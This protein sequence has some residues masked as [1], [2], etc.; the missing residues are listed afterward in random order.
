MYPHADPSKSVAA[1]WIQIQDIH[2][3]M[4]Y[5]R[6]FVSSFLRPWGAANVLWTVEYRLVRLQASSYRGA[7]KIH[8]NVQGH[9][10][11]PWRQK[12]WASNEIFI[13]KPSCLS[14]NNQIKIA[15]CWIP[16][17]WTFAWKHFDF[18][19]AV[20]HCAIPF[21]PIFHVASI[22]FECPT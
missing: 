9:L 5:Y 12:S 17:H 8:A 1:A 6:F 11:L 20:W 15:C 3:R 21:V 2:H 10:E 16:V 18:R 7:L 4:S 14:Y 22:S 13:E 19:C